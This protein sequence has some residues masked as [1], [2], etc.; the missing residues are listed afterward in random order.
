MKNRQSRSKSACV[1]I[2]IFVKGVINSVLDFNYQHA[3][4]GTRMIQVRVAILQFK[5]NL[6]CQCSWLIRYTDEIQKHF[7]S[8]SRC[9]VTQIQFGIKCWFKDS[10]LVFFKLN[11]HYRYQI[12]YLELLSELNGNCL[13]RLITSFICI[14]FI[15]K[16]IHTHFM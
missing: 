12:C 3:H 14:H 2:F 11:T 5:I 13:G 7:F 15:C 10:I 16:I 6:V 4:V 1:V 9:F 8:C